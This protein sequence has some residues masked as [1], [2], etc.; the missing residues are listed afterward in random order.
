MFCN[1]LQFNSCRPPEILHSILFQ[2]KTSITC[3]TIQKD[4]HKDESNGRIKKNL[5]CSPSPALIALRATKV[6]MSLKNT[7]L[8][9][10]SDWSFK[11]KLE[12]PEKIRRPWYCRGMVSKMARTWNRMR[13]PLA[14]GWNEK[15][16]W[17]EFLK[18]KLKAAQLTHEWR[19]E[20]RVQIS[21]RCR[22]PFGRS[23]W[24]RQINTFCFT[25]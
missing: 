17:N 3:G 12:S 9:L 14:E 4:W 6:E 8:S 11:Q 19:N 20:W 22:S 21:S 24:D 23:S 5:N 18:I 1:V 13:D 7:R 15:M 25:L 10:K 16:K 2:I